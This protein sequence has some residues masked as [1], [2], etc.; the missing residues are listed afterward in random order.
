M[1]SEFYPRFSCILARDI[2][3]GGI[4]YQ[5]KLPWIIKEDLEYFKY[6]TTTGGEKENIVIMGKNTFLSLGEKPLKNRINIVVS[7]TLKDR[8]GVFIVPSLNSALRLSKNFSGIRY[9]FVIGGV[10]L[11]EQAFY[12]QLLESIYITAVKPVNI[13]KYDTFFNLDIPTN[14]ELVKI[15]K[16]ETRDFSLVFEKYNHITMTQEKQYLELLHHVLTKGDEKNDRTGVGTLSYFSPQIY[17]DL[18]ETFPLLTTKRVPLRIVFEELMWFLRGQTNNKILQDKGVHIWDGN[19]SKEYMK[20]VGLSHY[21]EGELGP[22]YGAQW[23]NFGGDHDT[24]KT[25]H[26]EEGGIDQIKDVI[27]QLRTNPDSRRMIVCAWN[28]K[29]LQQMALPPCHILFQFYV[30][31]KKYLDCK[32]TIRSNDLFLGA[33]FNIASYSLL[34]YMIAA[35]TGYTPGKLVYSIGDAHIY[36]NHIEQVKEQI[37]RPLRSFP[38]VF[39]K[40]IP[41]NIEEFEF[42]DFEVINY[43]PHPTIKAEMAV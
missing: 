1:S 21:P 5:N 40:R 8:E 23:R 28:P 6:I 19:S 38:K 22:I 4:G 32:L 43:D 11:L 18:S 14:F 17:F 20:R 31:S 34:V 39:I 41:E 3:N 7:S 10:K 12:H 33:P 15:H 24:D 30:Q 9:V 25:N 29:A 13:I 2:Y 35:M 26:I 16:M 27:H 36:K 42:S 37:S